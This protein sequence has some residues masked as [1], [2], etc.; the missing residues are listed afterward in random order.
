VNA[1][2][3]ALGYFSNGTLVASASTAVQALKPSGA[4]TAFGSLVSAA[5]TLVISTSSTAETE[6]TLDVPAGLALTT[7]DTL[8]SVTTLTVNGT[9]T[10]SSATFAGL[11]ANVSGT[12]ALTAGVVGATEAPFIIESGLAQAALAST[13]I[14]DDNLTIPASTVRTFT[15]AAAP[16]AN[17]TVNGTLNVS[18]SLTIVATKSLTAGN[19]ILGTGTWTASGA[20][21]TIAPDVI[22]L[23]NNAA[24]KFGADDGTSAT[25]LT[26]TADVTN[27]FTASGGTVTLGQSTNKL[28]ITGSA[29]AATLTTGATAGI[30][31]KAGLDITTATVD[32]SVADTSV[33]SLV[34]ADANGVTLANSNSV[35]LLDSAKA[36]VKTNSKKIITNL[37]AGDNVGV[38]AESDT[39][40]AE[41]GKF[42]GAESDNT[43]VEGNSGFAIKK[44]IETAS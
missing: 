22:T 12:G 27:T 14:T 13:D 38:W 18:T 2:K 33:I 1:V 21:A 7:S 37:T 20:S 10:A 34:D 6:A 19:I 24:A 5:K 30:N 35:I 17:V 8:A 41:V 9:L 39:G 3:A 23:G 29:A 32:I 15:G 31:V 11:T 25:V 43:L 16:S 42:V 44:G 36:T 40:E 28:T 26:G 4:V